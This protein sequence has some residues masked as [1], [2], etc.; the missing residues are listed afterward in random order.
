MEGEGR[1]QHGD[2][3]VGEGDGAGTH[4]DVRVTYQGLQ[5]GGRLLRLDH[6]RLEDQHLQTAVQQGQEGEDEEGRRLAHK[7]VHEASKWRS[8]QDTQGQPAQCYPHGIS[9]LLVVRVPV[10]QHP[11]AGHA[12][13]GRPD[14]L[15][16][17]GEE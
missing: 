17:P 7:L 15:Q 1:L 11:H 2:A 13:A 10:S 14:T 6:L 12:G 8:Y 5:A 9:S 4:Q 3:H 16:G